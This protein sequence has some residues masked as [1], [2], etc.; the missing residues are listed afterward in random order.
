MNLSIEKL[1]AGDLVE[2]LAPA[3][4]IEKIHVETAVKTLEKMGLNV[5]VS[6]HCL[7]QFN[8]FSGTISE[9]LSDFQNAIND[10]EVKAIFCAR[11]GYGCIQL[12]DKLQWANML[13]HPKWI[14][15]FSDVT[16]FHQKLGSMGLKSIHGTMPLNF[17]LNSSQSL[18]TLND[19]LTG[20]TYSIKAEPSKYNTFGSASA[21]LHGGNLSIL[22]SLLGTDDCVDYTDSILFIEDLS[23]QI[24]HLDRMF[25]AL[26]KAG[27]LNRIKGLIVGGMTDMKDTAIP[28]GMSYESVILSHFEYRKIPICFNFP[29]GHINDNRALILG[30]NVEFNVNTTGSELLFL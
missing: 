19:A 11:G 27:V 1:K 18:S 26:A 9:R 7:G 4:S 2:I 23:E 25:Y 12:V 5:R 3:K 8:Y 28:F 10:D 6:K 24:Y 30:A 22:Y 20:K 16:V 21:T 17:A 29:A 13:R 14:V 15:G